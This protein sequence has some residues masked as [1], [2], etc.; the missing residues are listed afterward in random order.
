MIHL[1]SF[2][3]AFGTWVLTLWDFW[4]SLFVWILGDSEFTR[5]PSCTSMWYMVADMLFLCFLGFCG[6]LHLPGSFLLRTLDVLEFSVGFRIRI[7]LSPAIGNSKLGLL[8]RLNLRCTS[9]FGFPG[10]ATWP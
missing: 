1:L 8:Q 4:V 6:M 9:C 7:R 2:C 3:L 5:F 10:Q